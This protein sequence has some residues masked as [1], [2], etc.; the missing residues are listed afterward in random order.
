MFLHIYVF[1]FHL[2]TQSLG[3]VQHFSQHHNTLT[4]F[5]IINAQNRKRLFRE[6]CAC[7]EVTCLPCDFCA[8]EKFVSGLD[9]R[10]AVHGA[11][12]VK[13]FA[14]EGQRFSEGVWRNRWKCYIKMWL[15]NIC[16][17]VALEGQVLKWV[18][19]GK[20]V[21]YHECHIL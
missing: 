16:T 4:W 10:R 11:C 17:G 7:P 5:A 9:V 21:S 6:F 2:L 19:N 8:C 18:L 14:F 20:Y 15:C 3:H 1:L 12:D 13:G